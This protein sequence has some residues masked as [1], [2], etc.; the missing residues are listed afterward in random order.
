MR[1]LYYG[2]ISTTDGQ[3]SARAN[4]YRVA[5]R[6]CAG[7]LDESYAISDEFARHLL[8]DAEKELLAKD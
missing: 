1:K 5:S 2:R 3:S 8:K 6:Y 7:L 4:E